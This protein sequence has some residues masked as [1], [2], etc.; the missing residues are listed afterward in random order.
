MR[1]AQVG[2][3]SG[4]ARLLFEPLVKDVPYMPGAAQQKLRPATV[5]AWMRSP[6]LVLL[7]IS[8]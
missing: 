3:D 6:N 1:W 7:E 5:G 4:R 2:R 8:R